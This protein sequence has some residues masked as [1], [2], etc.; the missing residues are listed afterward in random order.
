VARLLALHEAMLAA[1]RAQRFDDAIGLVGQCRA[2]APELSAYYEA[3]A[4]FA[5][6]LRANPPEPGWDGVHQAESK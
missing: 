1:Y 5:A 4:G 3:F 6:M 2:L